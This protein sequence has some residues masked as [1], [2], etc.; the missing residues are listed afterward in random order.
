MRYLML[1]AL[2]GCAAP[3]S[4]TKIP[5]AVA[6]ALAGGEVSSLPI[7]AWTGPPV[8]ISM[9][10]YDRTLGFQID[11]DAA[12]AHFV[13]LTSAANGANALEARRSDNQR[14]TDIVGSLVGAVQQGMA[15]ASQAYGVRAAPAA[16]APPATIEVVPETE[17]VP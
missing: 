14:A 15:L 8:E 6:V 17:D 9:H 10:W 4:T 11:R 5:P 2:A 16:P 12:G 1:I 7:E 3:G 13:D